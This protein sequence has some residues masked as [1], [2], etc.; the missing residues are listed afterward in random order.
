MIFSRRALAVRTLG[1]AAVAALAL[2][3]VAWW[4]F[5]DAPRYL[6]GNTAKFD[7]LFAASG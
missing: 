2:G 5:H 7:R 1:A 3:G 6:S 4:S